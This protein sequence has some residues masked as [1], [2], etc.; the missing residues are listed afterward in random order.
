[1]AKSHP[2]FARF[3]ARVAPSAE[4]AGASDHRGE[5]LSGVSGRVIELG[6]GSGLCFAHYPNSVADVVAVEPEPFLRAVAQR[7]A[8][9][10]KVPIRVVAGEADELPAA[11]ESFD[12][13]VLSLVLCSVPDQ[14]RALSEIRRVLRPGGVLHFY[15]HVRSDNYRDAV[16]QDRVDWI[17][18][19]VLGGCHP[20]RD[21]VSAISASGFSL[22]DCRPF[23]FRP[24]ML[25]APAAPHVIGKAV[26]S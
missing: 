13:A 5:L 20:N 15:E 8:A 25:G 3:Y 6:A 16:W 19:R 11:D 17:W 9:A 7:A 4:R 24:I 2:V 14:R 12:A 22:E 23:D 21:T 10:S 26:R 18:S 1:M